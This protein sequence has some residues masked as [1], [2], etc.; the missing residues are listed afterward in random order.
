MKLR[1]QETYFS[2]RINVVRFFNAVKTS[3]EEMMMEGGQTSD[4]A[5]TQIVLSWTLEDI[6]NENLYKVEKIPESFESVQ[7][8]LGSFVYPLLEETRAQ[9]YSSMDMLYRLP[10]AKVVAFDETKP[11]G[12]KVYQVQVDYW[13]NRFNDKSKEPYKTLPGD[14]MIL[15]N[16]KPETFSDL[17]RT[18]RS[19]SFLSVSSITENEKIDDSS[20]IRQTMIADHG[21]FSNCT[22]NFKAK[23]SKEFELDMHM[24]TSLFVVFLGN[25]TTNKRVW[26]TLHMSCNLDLLEYV[27]S[28]RSWV[29]GNCITCPEE[30]C[31]KFDEK[32]VK[33]LSSNMNE[34]Q[35]SAVL[36]CLHM[37]Q[38]KSRGAL[39][40]VWGPPGTGKTKANATLLVS[41]LK[42]N[43]RT[44]VCAPTNVAITEVASR[45]LKIVAASKPTF[46]SLGDILLFGDME[47]LKIGSDIKDIFLEYRVQRIAECLGAD[48]WNHCFPS[49]INL[50]ERWVSQYC[51]FLKNELIKAQQK[52]CCETSI[53]EVEGT[54]KFN[55]FLDYVRQRFV[56]I[57]KQLRKYIW[58]LCTHLPQSFILDQN[59]LNMVTLTELLDR[60]ET[61][62]FG[63]TVIS[64]EIRQML[65]CPEVIA[66]SADSF[67]NNCSLLSVGRQC[68]S[69]LR[70]L[71]GSLE[72]LT[73]PNFRSKEEITEFCFQRASLIF[74]TASG[75]FQLH[76]MKIDPLAVLVIDEA[77]QL[78]ECES[79]I[80]L[81]L[82]G[83]R[84]AVLFGDECQLP[85]T[86]TSK[87][88]QEASFGR[89][90]FQRLSALNHSRHLLNTQYRMHP[91]ISSFP[92]ANFYHNQI[93]DASNVKRKSYEKRYLPG[94]MFGSYSFINVVGGREEK[95]DDGHSLKNMV[96][97]ALVI[98][99]LQN[100]Y[101][102]WLERKAKL[103][104]GVV[105][106]YSAQ[107]VSIREKV[108]K[109][110]E[111]VNGFRV[112]VKTIDG[113]QGGEEDII[114]MSTVIGESYCSI[115]QSL[116]FVS[117]PQIMNVALTRARHCLWILGNE[118]TLANSQSIWEA[119]VIDAKERHCF[120]NADEDVGLAKAMLE[121]KKELDQFDDLLNAD[122]ML[123]RNS[124]WKVLFSDNFL[125][126]FKKLT[127][128]G[129]KKSVLN[130][131]LKIS[132]GWRPK[133]SPSESGSGSSLEI[134]KFKVDGQIL[135]STVDISKN[136]NYFQVL[137]I[138]DVLPP[139]H[140]PKLIKRLD[141]IFGKY[142]DDFVNLCNERLFDG[143]LEIPKEWPSS[144][145]FVRLKDLFN[146]KSESESIGSSSDAI[147]YVENS[148]VNE[149][150]LLMKFYSLS[151][152]VVNHLLSD[153]DGREIDLPYEV[154]D[155]QM[156]IILVNE[157]SFILGRSGTGKT[158]VLT[159]K[160]LRREQLHLFAMDEICGVKTDIVGHV[161][162]N[163]MGPNNLV[164]N[165]KKVLRQ[166]FVTVSPKLCNAVNQHVSDLKRFVCG[167]NTN[168]NECSLIDTD[169]LDDE[170]TQ[171]KNI[172]NSFYDIPANYYPLVITLHKFLMMLDGTL[173][174][175]YF[176]RFLNVE[177]LSYD[178]GRNSRSVLLQT[179]IRNKEVNYEKFSVLYWHHFDSKLTKKLDPSRVFT[180]IIS[181]IKGGLMS[182]EASD[183][184]LSREDYLKMSE[185]HS[186]NLSREKRERIYDIFQIYERKKME[187]GEFD[188][189]DFVNDLHSRLKHEGYNADEMNFVYID[190]VQ[191]LTMSQITLFK[192]ICGNVEEGFVFSGDTAQ[193]IARGVDF[194]FED[195]RHL[196]Y[197]KFV[198]EQ[199]S[200]DGERKE[201]GLISDIFQLSQ[202]FRTHA[203]ILKLSQSIIELI[204]H[205][206]PH[207]I[208]PLKPETSLIYG[209]SPLLL[210]C[211]DD[212]NAII[213]I[214]GNS[215]ETSRSIAGFGAEQV[216]L[217]RDDNARKEIAGYVGKKALLLTVLECK[218]LEFQDVLLYNFFGSSPLKNQ[219]RVIYEYMKER[220]LFDKTIP[221]F[222]KFSESKHNILCSELKHLYV[223]VTRTRQRLW[224]CES[225]EIAEPIFDYW[226]K[227]CLV[228]SKPLDDSFAQTMQVTSSPEE[229]RSRGIKLFQEHN[230][231]MATM[232]FERAGD[233]Y[234]EGLS[235]AAGLKAA[236]CRLRISNP[237]EANSILG[238]AAKIFEAI[239]KA[240]SAARCLSDLGEYEN[241]GRLYLEKC[242][243]SELQKAGEC[244]SLA[245]RHELA[246]NAYARGNFFSE[247]LTACSNGRLF[248]VGLNYIK[249][250]K[251]HTTNECSIA[252]R[253]EEIDRIEQMFLEK[254][255]F[256]YFQIND[257][258]SIME[259]VKEFNSMDSI[260]NF[261]TSLCCLDELLL[262]EEENK[263]FME[264]ANIAKLIGD[265]LRSVDLLGKAGK[266]K[267][268]AKLILFYVL[269]KSLWSPGS[270][271]WPLK[272]FKE[273]GD[274]LR[275]AKTFARND[276]ESFYEIVC[277]EAD[278][279][280]NEQRDLVTLM[281]Q[282]A[283]SQRQKSVSGEILTARII[284]DMHLSSKSIKYYWEEELVANSA[285]FVEVISKNQ[286]S[287]ESLIFFWN[288]WTNKI[289]SVFE[290]LTCLQTQKA[291]KFRDYGEFCL[292]YLGVWREFNNSNPTFIFLYPEAEWSKNVAKTLN[293]GKFTSADLHEFVCAA[294]RYWSSE[295][296]SVG[297]M[298]LD[299]LLALYDF[300]IDNIFYKSR[301]LTQI[302]EV[303][304]FLLEAKFL[305]LRHH[306]SEILLKYIKFS[307]ENIVGYIFPEWPK[308]LSKNMI[309]LRG[310]NTTKSMLNRVIAESDI[311]SNNPTHGEVGRIAMIILGSGKVNK[312]LCQKI[313]TK[314]NCH[315]MWKPWK[316]FFEV[317]SDFLDDPSAIGLVG[318]CPFE[319]FQEALES[320][321]NTNWRTVD[322][323][324]PNCFL[325]LVEY[326]L[327]WLSTANGYFL[328][329]KS[330]FVEF[331]LTYEKYFTQKEP[332]EVVHEP[333]VAFLWHVVQGLLNNKMETLQWIGKFTTKV[334]E[335]YSAL[336]TRLVVLTCLIYVN[337]GW[338]TSLL[339]NV[340][341]KSDIT[342]QLPP[343]FC[344]ALKRVRKNNSRTIKVNLIA[345]A[346]KK[347]DN[348]MLIVNLMECCPFKSCP[349]AAYISV[350]LSSSK[351]EILATLF[352]DKVEAS[353]SY[354]GV[355]AVMEACSEG[356]LPSSKACQSSIAAA[357]PSTSQNSEIK[358]KG[359]NKFKASKDEVMFSPKASEDEG[360]SLSK[361]CQVATEAAPSSSQNVESKKQR[362]NKSKKNKKKSKGKKR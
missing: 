261:L 214:F 104:I 219:W 19:W 211:V 239:G 55:P 336:V 322:Y 274:L 272:K 99:I 108:G 9:L 353:K 310:L 293:S 201:K 116:D 229:W 36:A 158:T 25:L 316:A 282:R 179:L 13:R 217:V 14:I 69:I 82:P 27:L 256:H 233:A 321:Y 346:F 348:P 122:S 22:T 133:K 358:N 300:P 62:L 287:I 193:T 23:S 72:K 37:M 64:E 292:N 117:K 73:F 129:K 260:R 203:G 189:A 182:I 85:A 194:R 228:Q 29:K 284:L 113:F 47:R 187:S 4:C 181:H 205:F 204:Y 213:K 319:R 134:M 50:L 250:W 330:M 81:Q 350:S 59:F 276:T 143:N 324:S 34:S 177:D 190:E 75:S 57:V 88:S 87:I 344:A 168:L 317:I 131:L 333:I 166:L 200:E 61:L 326:L 78:K 111:N 327:I 218:G 124:K 296:L 54:E 241:A 170:E 84:H 339:V 279:I 198:L 171:F 132:S 254:C 191:D 163:I 65:S 262:L 176:E 156:E 335:H 323:I 299:R 343:P 208:D 89:S 290:Y 48:G 123:F 144:L 38:C 329:P 105:S 71:L 286:V 42:M 118:R 357:A 52:Q 162:E 12:E 107:V 227:K 155:E 10:Y 126:S 224:I 303:A 164:E 26:K 338:N 341:K 80:P 249:F 265:T 40:L 103:S 332:H 31:Y 356:E 318:V 150:L 264:A 340:M 97:V 53:K 148:K 210:H 199:K 95:D 83:I 114:I 154:T 197:K 24:K 236:A 5:M 345:E 8:Y 46:F 137:K 334:T 270:K 354:V 271:G 66:D 289:A 7:H 237:K 311:L 215:G 291:Y 259:F 275:K 128:I 145:D 186:S 285:K 172:P 225:S 102:G 288:Y 243:E 355:E 109:K 41:L 302:Y 115:G 98:K 313:I 314:L 136:L 298:V 328:S 320:T 207:S 16:A 359:S 308:P 101:E 307:T 263:N 246:A 295:M 266:F 121:M 212:E 216:I 157:S 92:N 331:L 221:N 184:K 45:V 160:L 138:W 140:V 220:D 135:I 267:D 100:L 351:K 32:L 77:A 173:S 151:H 278:I 112:K 67:V 209:E 253:S 60:F 39:E 312:E 20:A 167:G 139:D 294:Q 74:S 96:E 251:Q 3:C 17:E 2:L 58:I 165:G 161:P 269:A 142:T 51:V 257:K 91:S 304:T 90:L 1:S 230:Y 255:A 196:F 188:L 70:T 174:K 280:C 30:N 130:H 342:E 231:E 18:G 283:T 309:I 240:D 185:G 120:Y 49:M 180:E 337:F 252:G 226:R 202:N 21:P 242:G 149:S 245:G 169:D 277:N 178:Q 86:V 223:A 247:C 94:S 235:K 127:P 146:N 297:V 125:K 244:F 33:S 234:W 232:C 248:E 258:R 268:S 44:L 206:F 106:P 349:D 281:S 183:G 159:M 360:L 192:H 79:T 306:E 315:E 56:F 222:P 76:L 362:G 175:S 110:Y 273:R 152:G 15:V 68:L 28:N 93:L 195:I 147:S 141:N 238:E 325:Y 6:S 361:V 153:R 305:K 11:H 301:V 119:L 43:Y 347:I 63:D 352:P 35:T